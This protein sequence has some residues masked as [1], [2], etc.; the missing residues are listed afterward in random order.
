M[1][2]QIVILERTPVQNYVSVTAVFWIPVPSGRE[3]LYSDPNKTSAYRGISS[4]EMSEL[5]DGKV[6]EIYNSNSFDASMTVSQIG[7]VLV[8]QWNEARAG[9][10]GVNTL[11]YYGTN[12]NGT[13]WTVKGV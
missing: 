12:W 6:V 7:Q 8:D 13:S 9:V 11:G 5:K 1:A 3:M 10:T 4:G 2:K